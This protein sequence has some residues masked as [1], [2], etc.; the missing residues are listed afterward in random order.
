[1]QTIRTFLK[2]TLTALVCSVVF[3]AS[4]FA[5]GPVETLKGVSTTLMAELNKND[6]KNNTPA[7]YAMVGRVVSPYIDFAEMARWVIGRQAWQSAKPQE[8]KAFTNS[9]RDLMIRTYAG[10][11]VSYQH[12][13]IEFLPLRGGHEGKKRVQVDTIVR[14]Q[15]GEPL[16]M[17]YRVWLSGDKWRVYDIIIEGVSLLKGFQSQFADALREGG[18]PLVT[19]RIREHNAEQR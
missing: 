2:G 17:S 9:F 4:V 6:Y 10:S 18:V 19:E 7:L 5:Q 12:Y 16:H 8:Q 15:G 13:E 14:P 3:S 11:L 1:M